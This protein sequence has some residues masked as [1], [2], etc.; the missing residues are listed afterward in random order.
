VIELLRP[1]LAALLVAVVSH[2]NATTYVTPSGG[3]GVTYVPGGATIGDG[4]FATLLS[5]NVSQAGLNGVSVTEGYGIG[6]GGRQIG[7]TAAR[8]LAAGEIAAAAAALGGAAWAGAQ[9]GAPISRYLGHDT[10][11]IGDTRCVATNTGWQCDD[12]GASESQEIPLYATRTRGNASDEATGYFS[13]KSAACEES[14]RGAQKDNP[15]INVT[16]EVS[17][18]PTGPLGFCRILTNG[19]VYYTGSFATKQGTKNTCDAVIDALNPAYSRPAGGEPDADGKCQTGRY[20]EAPNSKVADRL[21]DYGKPE[22]MADVLKDLLSKGGTAATESSRTM[23]GPQSITGTPTTSTTTNPDGSTSTTT[24]T[25]TTNYNY[26]GSTINYN[27][28][29]TTT[30]VNN[31]TGATTTTTTNQTPQPNAEDPCAKHPGSVGCMDVGKPPTDGPQWQTRNID[32]AAEDLGMGGACPPPG[33]ITL[34]V[35]AW[36][37]TWSYQPACDVAPVIRFGLLALTAIGCL[38]WVLTVVRT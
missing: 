18:P 10:V 11:D 20:S 26:Q 35:H 12:G 3:I 7:V 36:V 2:A 27:I 23:S 29:T 28:S 37:L 31:S 24:T 1:L 22:N 21:R 14:M 34:P 25:P 16:M 33:S 38:V 15:T 13:S 17:G 19:Q 8:T 6:L 9:I 30:T 5:R 4:G 32:F